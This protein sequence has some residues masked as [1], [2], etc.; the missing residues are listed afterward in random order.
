MLPEDELRASL[1]IDF[2]GEKNKKGEDT[3]PQPHIVGI[4]QP[5]LAG[6]RADIA[7]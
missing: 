5:N 6:N 4:L 3:T 7:G 1:I 2:E